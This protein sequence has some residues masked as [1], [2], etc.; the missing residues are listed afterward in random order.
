M[1]RIGNDGQSDVLVGDT[2]QALNVRAQMVFN[3][4]R[5][6]E[7]EGKKNEATRKTELLINS[8]VIGS[9]ETGELRKD[10]LKWLAANIR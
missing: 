9:F 1:G 8:Y 2:V 5:A 7:E 3:V 4:T 10:L 6:L